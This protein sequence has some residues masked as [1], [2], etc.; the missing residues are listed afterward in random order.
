MSPTDRASPSSKPGP[1]PFAAII[2]SDQFAS[3]SG[4]AWRTVKR[5]ATDQA[6]LRGKIRTGTEDELSRAAH[7]W[8][9]ASADGGGKS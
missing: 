1:T 7:C 5:T 4:I 9:L 6:D 8:D 3:R 2:R